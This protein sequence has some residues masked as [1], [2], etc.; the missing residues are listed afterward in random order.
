MARE[1]EWNGK[2]VERHKKRIEAMFGR[3]L[4]DGEMIVFLYVWSARK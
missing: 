3:P 2:A 4:T 1:N